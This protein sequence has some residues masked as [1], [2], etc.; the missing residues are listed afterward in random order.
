MPLISTKTPCRVHC[1][2]LVSDVSDSVSDF[3]H[4]LMF[5]PKSAFSVNAYVISVWSK[6]V[7]VMLRPRRLHIIS[8]LHF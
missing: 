1:N 6:S 5:L 2:C 7:R 3:G 4:F 8:H